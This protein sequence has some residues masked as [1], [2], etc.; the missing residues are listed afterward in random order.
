MNI[1]G[2]T[3]MDDLTE[4]INT[5]LLGEVRYVNAADVNG[6][7]AIG[8]DDLTALINMLLTE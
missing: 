2:T 7:R 8:M 5:L 4:L 3:D 6:D 1:D